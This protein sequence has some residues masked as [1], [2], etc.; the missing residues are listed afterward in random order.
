MSVPAA[1]FTAFS[2]TAASA[3]SPNVPAP[4]FSKLAPLQLM[5]STTFVLFAADAR[6][7]LPP[8]THVKTELS[9]MSAASTS[10]VPPSTVSV[11]PL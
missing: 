3:P 1:T 7:S 9:P 11:A 2:D 8:F 10:S 4:V 6:R 5:A